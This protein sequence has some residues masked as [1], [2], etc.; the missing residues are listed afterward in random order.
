[1]I[2]IKFKYRG[3]I[4]RESKQKLL[5]ILASNGINV[6]KPF[7]VSDG[8]ALLIEHEHH[9]DKIFTNEIKQELEKNGFTAN[10]PPQF[11]VKKS[12][13]LTR[14][15]EEIYDRD[16]DT[17]IAELKAQ[18]V[19]I[20]DD[21]NSIYKF[22]NSST[23]KI[24]FNQTQLAKTCCEKGLLAFSLSIPPSEIKQETYIQ[25]ASIDVSR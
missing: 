20:G 3:S 10:I 12:V 17:I 7:L 14:L 1:M 2:R 4:N 5:G 22:P 6:V 8:F 11:K 23:V 13:L 9:A 19:W 24:T 25:S 21:I 16:E 18:N 15:D